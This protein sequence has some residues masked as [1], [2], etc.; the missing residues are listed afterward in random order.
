MGGPL[1]RGILL[2]RLDPN[3]GGIFH[4]WTLIEVF[5]V[6]WTLIEELLWQSSFPV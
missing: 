1:S 5:N 3:R 4:V 6:V 2:S